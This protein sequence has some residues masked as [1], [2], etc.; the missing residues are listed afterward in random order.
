[1]FITNNAESRWIAYALIALLVA[2]TS[3]RVVGALNRNRLSHDEVISYLATTGHLGEYY[4]VDQ[5]VYPFGEWV[6]APVWREFLSLNKSLSFQ[7]IGSDL[8]HHDIHP[9]LYFWLLRAWSYLLGAYL[10]AGL[11][12][13]ILIDVISL[14]F[15]YKLARLV[16]G[17]KKGALLTI[18]LWFLSP[19]VISICLW[20]RQYCLLALCAIFFVWQIV[21]YLSNVRLSPFRSALLSLSTACGLLTHYHFALLILGAVIFSTMELFKKEERRLLQIFICL[22]IGCVLFFFLHP[23]FYLSFPIQRQQAEAFRFIDVVPRF[24]GVLA[25]GVGF[26][27]YGEPLQN[28]AV[29]ALVLLVLFLVWCLAVHRCESRKR[30]SYFLDR[31]NFSEK[32]I[33]YLAFWTMGAVFFLYLIFQSPKHAVD[34]K[35]LSLVWPLVTLVIVVVFRQISRSKRWLALLCLGMFVSSTIKMFYPYFIQ[36]N[37]PDPV[38][39]LGQARFVL[40]DNAKPGEL[41]RIVWHLPDEALVYSAGQDRLLESSSSWLDNLPSGSIYVSHPLHGNTLE[42]ERE[43][44]SLIGQNHGVTLFHQETWRLDR[45]FEVN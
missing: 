9:P 32:F 25:S 24:L 13:N 20:V 35:Y 11:W 7:E 38:E 34:V 28:V 41:L 18:C 6:R 37:S 30:L 21:Q 33:I 23:Q 15:L 1:M 5:G 3:L 40:I 8:A 4:S 17:S 26:F 19:A 2:G 42:G 14:F 22:G 43:I 36:R 10:K 45:F 44:L 12:L 29:V 27:V 16:L 39:M 31:V